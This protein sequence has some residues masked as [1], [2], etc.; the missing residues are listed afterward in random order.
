MRTLLTDE[1][2]RAQSAEVERSA[3]IS[4]LT[5]RGHAVRPGLLSRRPWTRRRTGGYFSHDTAGHQHALHRTHGT[6]R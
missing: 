4:V 1:L 5:A 2:V 6:A 3:R